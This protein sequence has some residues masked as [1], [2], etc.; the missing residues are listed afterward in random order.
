MD[1]GRQELVEGRMGIE[2]EMRM[3]LMKMPKLSLMM[4]RTGGRKGWIGRG[5]EN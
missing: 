2:R 4:V 1:E 5:P 3:K